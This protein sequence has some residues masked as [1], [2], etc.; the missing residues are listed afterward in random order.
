MTTDSLNVTGGPA[1]QLVALTPEE[2]LYDDENDNE[3]IVAGSEFGVE[4]EA[5]DAAGNLDESYNGNVTIALASNPNG[6][7]LGGTLTETAVNGVAK[8][9]NLTI[10]NAGNN[11]V[12]QASGTGL[13]SGNTS[14]FE[15][16]DQ[17]VVTAPPPTSVTAGTGFGF[18][19]E[20]Q[21]AN[22]DLDTQFNGPVT[23]VLSN[24]SGGSPDFQAGL[25][26]VNAV[27]GVATFSGLELDQAGAYGIFIT[28]GASAPGATGFS[29]VPAAASQLAVT[30]QPPVV[31]QGAP[32][33]VDVSAEDPFG[34]V[35]TSFAG[36]VTL[37]LAKNPGD[38]TL[39]GTLTV[40]A[41]D[42]VASFSDLTLNSSDNGYAIQA[43]A[44]GLT[45]AATSA[46]D[47]LPTGATTQLSVTTAPPISS[48]P[49]A[50][51]GW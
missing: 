41:I 18:Q 3:G 50:S 32:F 14:P 39:G 15:I 6:V 31:T 45:S 26:T 21:D 17:M 34:N 20:A 49:A 16:V 4:V 51:S 19:V 10:S 37:S 42:G 47:V 44:T 28:S 48:Q 43:V 5:E 12:L 2:S 30:N 33:E 40:A 25:T 38:A 23:L 46:I 11:Y 27:N 24:F 1:T 35:E 29:I 13:T 7:T 8:F 9:D 22:G 36:N